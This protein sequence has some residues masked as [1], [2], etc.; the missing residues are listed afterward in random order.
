[1]RIH[2]CQAIRQDP[3]RLQAYERRLRGTSLAPRARLLRLLE[4][5]QARSLPEATALLG[6]STVPVT[7]GW[8]RSRQ[9]GWAGLLQPPTRPGRPGQRTLAAWHGLPPERRAGRI[10]RRAEARPYRPPHW[11]L[12]YRSVPGIWQV[13]RQRR[14]PCQTGRGTLRVRQ[15]RAEAAADGGFPKS[16]GR[17]LKNVHVSRVLTWEEGRF[18]WRA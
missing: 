17:L 8:E 6:Y 7:R 18:G 1:M 9:R 5:G 3:K 13:L 2:Y 4:A 15:R 10:T 12:P 11:N 16:F 14:V